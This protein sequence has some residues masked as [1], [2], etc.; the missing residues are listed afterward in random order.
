M[1]S[2]KLKFSEQLLLWYGQHKRNLPW[3]KTKDPYKILLSEILLQQTQVVRGTE[4]YKQFLKTFPNI[5]TLAAAKPEAVLKAWEGAGYYARARNFHRAA[6]QIAAQ[7]FP[8]TLAGLLALPGVG[9]YTAAAVA[10]IA[11]GK[12]IALVDGNVRRVLARLYAKAKPTE[13]WLWE[14]AKNFM[15]EKSAQKNPGDWNQALMELGATICT[16]KNPHC[17]ICPVQKYCAAKQQNKTS[18]IPVPKT[19]AKT[20]QVLAV[21]LVL[22]NNGRVFL[23]E[24][25]SSGLLAGLHG[26]PLQEIFSDESLALKK[27]Q[28]QFGLKARAQYLGEITHA[29]THRYFVVRVYAAK[30]N[31][32]ALIK[33]KDAAL[34]RLDQKILALK[35]L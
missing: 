2:Q 22:H 33:P 31:K 7:G 28:Q 13:N 14:A 23:E 19:R 9:P 27:L 21:A 26:L 3:R 18:S 20:K 29:M 8:K 11:F 12:P 1:D 35:K 30:T 24:R 34:A 17:E 16:P 15:Q 4:H 6:Q 5:K 10:S 25:P 32:H